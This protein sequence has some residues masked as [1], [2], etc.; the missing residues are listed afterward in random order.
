MLANHK[1]IT[2]AP[3]SLMLV[4]D[5]VLY[6]EA[7]AQLFTLQHLDIIAQVG[8][9]DQM[10]GLTDH[11]APDVI[12]ADPCAGGDV[13]IPLISKLKSMYSGSRIALILSPC[14]NNLYMELVKM[15]VSAIILKTQPASVLLKA[16]DKLLLN[17]TFFDKS[18]PMLSPDNRHADEEQGLAH[19]M[20]IE[21]DVLCGLSKREREI[22]SLVV[23]GLNTVSIALALHISEKTV[24]NHIYSI[25][26]KLEV[27]NRLELAMLASRHDYS[28]RKTA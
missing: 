10:L 15:G 3:K 11:L 6:R 20:V 14:S 22:V 21:D 12:V 9:K 13:S 27:K 8:F 2:Q 23:N 16:I 17:E 24:R 26:G 1:N 7:L 4:G 19:E 25:Y 5:Q 18:I 28:Q